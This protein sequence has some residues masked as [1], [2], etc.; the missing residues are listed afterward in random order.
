MLSHNQFIN[1]ILG[2]RGAGKSYG[3]KKWCI[4]DFIKRG[5]QFVWVRRYREE[6][7]NIQSYFA[8]IA[9]AYPG[10]TFKVDGKKAY[11]DGKIAGYFI[12][13]STSSRK[14]SDTYPN[15]NKIIFDEFIIDKGTIRY[16]PNEVTLFLELVETIFRMRDDCRIVLIANAISMVN[17]YFLYWRFFPEEGREFTKRGVMLIQMVADEDFI[18]AKYKTKFG[19]LIRGTAY[20]DYAIENKFLRDNDDFIAK[21][22]NKAHYDGCIKYND[23]YYGI[24]TD[25]NEGLVYISYKCNKQKDAYCITKS[26]HSVNTVLLSNYRKIPLLKNLRDLFALGLIRFESNPIKNQMYEV[27]GLLSIK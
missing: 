13:L 2:N 9:S 27:M 8:D 3:C 22:S 14:K 17:P 26:D 18:E 12:I 10:H 25:Y 16:V 11:I 4:D 1:F 23:N 19:Q 24:W 6:I 15:V 7:S 21:K 20:G 5:K